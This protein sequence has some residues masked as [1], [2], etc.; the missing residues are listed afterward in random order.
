VFPRDLLAAVRESV[1]NH[2]NIVW[3]FAGSNAIEELTHADW[4]SAFVSLRTIELPP[5]GA[6]ETR[7]LLTEPVAHSGCGPG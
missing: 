5:F 4:T 6:E 7:L 2:R 1:Q 3:L